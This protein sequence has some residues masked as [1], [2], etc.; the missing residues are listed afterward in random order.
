MVRFFPP[1]RSWSSSFA[2]SRCLGTAKARVEKWR[3][4]LSRT[5]TF[6]C[7]VLTLVFSFLFRFLFFRGTWLSACLLAHTQAQGQ[8]HYST[9]TNNLEKQGQC[10]LKESK[11]SKSSESSKSSKSSRPA[12]CLSPF[13]GVGGHHSREQ[14]ARVYVCMRW[15]MDDKKT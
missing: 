11:S 5:S 12:T 4:C 10:E 6:R 3:V 15:Q 9:T 1:W 7:L 13:C 8:H 2:C 14:C